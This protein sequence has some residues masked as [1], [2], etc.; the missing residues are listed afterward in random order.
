MLCERCKQEIASARPSPEQPVGAQ[1]MHMK[2]RAGLETDSALGQFLGRTQSCV[3]Q[4]RRKGRVPDAMLIRF[5]K[6]L[7]RDAA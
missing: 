6:L 2:L 5:E 4:W 3:A 1:I 7:A